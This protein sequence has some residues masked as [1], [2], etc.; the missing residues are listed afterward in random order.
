MGR[1]KRSGVA[2]RGS[3][4]LGLALTASTVVEPAQAAPSPDNAPVPV[5][6]DDGRVIVPRAGPRGDVV[7]ATTGT[8]TQASGGA[9]LAADDHP[10]GESSPPGA[11][12][13]ESVIE[14]DKR[15]R[16]FD[17]TQFPDRAVEFITFGGGFRCTGWMVGRDT[18]ATAG[19]C[20]NRGGG[21]GFYSRTS[22]RIYP[23]RNG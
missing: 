17:T 22:Y 4:A 11:L 8:G 14:P 3:L 2:A 20:V 21:A 6:A 13:V 5:I 19:H 23:G 7:P 15:V 1:R 10:E 9:A 18:V 12:G 16:D